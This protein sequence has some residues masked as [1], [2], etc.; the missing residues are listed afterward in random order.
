M[1]W[2]LDPAQADVLRPYYCAETLLVF[3]YDGTL[4][5]IVRDP[6][7]A[8]M[9]PE[10]H[11]LLACVGRLYPL[12]ILT[13]RARQDVLQ[14]LH[15]V[16]VLDVIGNHGIEVF[17]AALAHAHARV[18]EWRREL[19][20]RLENLAGVI[21]EDKR[22]SLAVHF[23]ECSD[24]S[25]AEAAIRRIGLQLEGARLIG[26]KRVV[27]IVLAGAADKGVALRRLRERLAGPPAV[28]VGDD[29]TD[30]DAFAVRSHEVIG[31]RIGMCERSSAEYFLRE[32]Q[33]IDGLLRLLIAGARDRA[34][35]SGR[36][37]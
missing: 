21:I 2:I 9:R 16:P 36:A 7:H 13:G 23:R 20:E 18:S 6:A 12:A 19:E 22:A 34:T 29:D 24:P 11:A 25:M 31:I 10:T 1:K 3:D 32:Q 5:P 37:S 27:N 28:F 33:E 35:P 8:T 30:E 17:G 15:G 4:A 14:F 26:G